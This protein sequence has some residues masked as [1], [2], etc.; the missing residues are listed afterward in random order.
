MNRWKVYGEAA[1]S[2]EPLWWGILIAALLVAL[3]MA[4][5]AKRKW[6]LHDD[7]AEQLRRSRAVFGIVFLYWGAIISGLCSWI[8]TLDTHLKAASGLN[9]SPTNQVIYAILCAVCLVGGF[10]VLA[11]ELRRRTYKS[12][13]PNS[14]Q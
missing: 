13:T 12:R 2:I 9:C 4:I 14:R 3:V 8:C 1:K 10:V 5:F 11:W 7:Q 6:M